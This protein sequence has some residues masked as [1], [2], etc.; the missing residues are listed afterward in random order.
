M[1][2]SEKKQM[3]NLHISKEVGI[4]FLRQ[5]QRLPCLR[6]LFFNSNSFLNRPHSFTNFSLFFAIYVLP[7]KKP[8]FQCAIIE[9]KNKIIYKFHFEK[10][11][12]KHQ[13]FNHSHNS[14][15]HIRKIFSS[16]EEVKPPKI[17]FGE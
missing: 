11:V 3:M 6:G 14:T 17:A 7:K 16:L 10:I 12:S 15:G 2:M 8:N 9:S 5:K 4:Y 13:L 1:K